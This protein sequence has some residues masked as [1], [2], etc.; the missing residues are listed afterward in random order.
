MILNSLSDSGM[1]SLEFDHGGIEMYLMYVDESG[2]CGALKDGSP[3]RHFILSGL[4][5][6]ELRWKD[7][8]QR[9]IDFRI[10]MKNT[11]QIR[12]RDEIHAAA[13]LSRNS[14]CLSFLKR[15]DRLTV[16][17][18]FLNEIAT[19]NDVSIINVLV[20]KASK[21]DSYNV[22]EMA[23]K[24]L[25][26]RFENTMRNKNFPGPANPDDRG[27]LFPDHTD[28]KKLRVLIRKMR[29]FNPIPN[30]QQFGQ[31]YRDIPMDLVI[32]DPNIRDSKDSYFIQAA[33]AVA[34]F[35]K[36]YMEPN[37]YMRKKSGH[38]YFTRLEPV[39]C[40]CASS[41]DQFGIVR[42]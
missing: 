41:N 23:W 14:K 9:L 16:L 29:R 6:H 22:F 33:D 34:F 38:S 26:Q 31:G 25:L 27:S 7:T 37:S 3:T 35:L 32:E 28:D 12:L 42:L 39:L 2:D 18:H 21:T 15:H 36:Q 24:A 1:L 30:Q 13:M 10:R 11:F 20:D 40:K 4:V 17:R 5:V 8:L 19:L